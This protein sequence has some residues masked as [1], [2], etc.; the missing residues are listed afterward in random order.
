MEL[1]RALQRIAY[2][3]E[4]LKQA[5]L[6]TIEKIHTLEDR[7]DRELEKLANKYEAEIRSTA[8]ELSRIQQKITHKQVKDSGL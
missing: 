2:S 8:Q 3:A 6:L 7:R 4:N 5:E 1:T